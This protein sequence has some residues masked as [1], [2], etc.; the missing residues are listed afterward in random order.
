MKILKDLDSMHM[1]LCQ[2]MANYSIKCVFLSL[3]VDLS[4]LIYGGI[5]HLYETREY[6]IIFQSRSFSNLFGEVDLG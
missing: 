5:H 1:N 4:N 6:H 2:E 3:M